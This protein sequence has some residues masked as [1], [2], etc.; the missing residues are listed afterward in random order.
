MGEPVTTTDELLDLLRVFKG[1]REE[2]YALSAL[3]V[4]GS[5]ARNEASDSSDVDIVFET[6]RPN[7][8]RTV[9]L[10]RELEELLQRRVDVVRLRESMNPRLKDRI[11]REARY[12]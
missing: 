12:V 2:E 3:G 7:L 1:R 9:R 4:F 10:K 6:R 8:L 5:F 11:L